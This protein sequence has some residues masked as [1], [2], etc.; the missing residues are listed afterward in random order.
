M[1]ANNH[2]HI[3]AKRCVYVL[4]QM[5]ICLTQLIL[6]IWILLGENRLKFIWAKI[7]GSRRER[8]QDDNVSLELR[9]KEM[10]RNVGMTQ[11]QTNSSMLRTTICLGLMV[12]NF[13]LLVLFFLLAS[14][15][16]CIYIRVT[17]SNNQYFPSY[18]N[19]WLTLINNTFNFWWC[20]LVCVKMNAFF[21]NSLISS[22]PRNL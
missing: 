21:H 8:N 15:G 17:S 18:E 19:S 10:E 2:L 11:F 20:K 13:I 12:S 4:Q 22:L 6:F 3:I 7:I 14:Y 1:A 9:L 16:K 5:A